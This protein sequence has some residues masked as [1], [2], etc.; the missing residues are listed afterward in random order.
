MSQAW[1]GI[2][3]AFGGATG[4]VTQLFPTWMGVGVAHTPGA[5]AAPGAQVRQP[6]QGKLESIQVQTDGTNGGTIEIWDVNGEDAGLDMSSDSTP[7]ISDT[8]LTGL[9]T[10]GLAKL[11]YAQ[12]FTSTAGAA[13]PS[14]PFRAFS[15]GLAARFIGA[16]GACS[17]NLVVEGGAWYRQ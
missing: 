6:R 11:I 16:A 17:L 15:R 1:S 8:I 14:A 2:S 4:D 7:L 10:R 5:P 3:L 9:V 13:T 12:N